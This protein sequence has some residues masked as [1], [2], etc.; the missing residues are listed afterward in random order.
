MMVFCSLDYLMI[1]QK[2]NKNRQSNNRERVCSPVFANYLMIKRCSAAQQAA[3]RKLN[4]V[5]AGQFPCVSF[6]KIF[7]DLSRNK[8]ARSR[9]HRERRTLGAKVATFCP[10]TIL[11]RESATAR[12]LGKLLLPFHL[13]AGIAPG[14]RKLFK[15]ISIFYLSI[16]LSILNYEIR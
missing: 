14:G 11:R 9:K 13:V 12:A 8:K 6:A 5:E 16:Y 7:C 3:E 1:I 15:S 2:E 10:C 4:P